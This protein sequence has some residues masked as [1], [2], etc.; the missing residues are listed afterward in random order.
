MTIIDTPQINAESPVF[1]VV[2]FDLYRDIHKAIRAELFAI[3]EA[4]GSVGPND[5]AGLAAL[6]GHVGDVS[7]MLE[8]HA[9]HEDTAI[10]EILPDVLPGVS[11]RIEA[12]HLVLEHRFAEAVELVRANAAGE[13][14]RASAHQAY[15][16][17]ASFTSVY[18]AHQEL[19][20]LV[21][22]PALERAI[23]VPGVIEIHGKII[24]S[25]PPAEFAKSL[26]L[27]LRSMNVDDRTDMLGGIRATAPAEV[28]EGAWALASSAL[29]PRDLEEVAGRLGLA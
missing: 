27:M 13:G 6:A 10:G 2:T 8:M 12:D 15:L 21:V 3:T 1:Q 7:E 18:L 20:E 17:L 16:T 14:D 25:I 9:H 24:G 5:A 19:E 22:M 23:G 26:P 11:E 4:A 29:P 28:F